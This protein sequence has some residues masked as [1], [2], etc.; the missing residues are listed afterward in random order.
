MFNMG[1]SLI[2]D[3]LDKLQNYLSGINDIC[4][5]H[6]VLDVEQESK[7]VLNLYLEATNYLEMSREE[8]DNVSDSHPKFEAILDIY[9]NSVML[10]KNVTRGVAYRYAHMICITDIKYSEGQDIGD[11]LNLDKVRMAKKLDNWLNSLDLYYRYATASTKELNLLEK[12]DRIDDDIN[13]AINILDGVQGPVAVKNFLI[14][15]LEELRD[16]F[17]EIDGWRIKQNG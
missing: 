10:Y 13:A 11:A 2:L 16:S 12:P 4:E 7:A 15:Y 5:G 6:Q 1:G 17:I 14:F 9:R 8:F 3:S